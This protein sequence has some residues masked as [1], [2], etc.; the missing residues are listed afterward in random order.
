V[1]VALVWRVLIDAWVLGELVLALVT[2]TWRGGQDRG[3]QLL[4]WAVI[5]ASVW[6]GGWT[7]ARHP[8]PMPFPPH[9]VRSVALAFLFVGLLI[10][11]AAIFSLKRAFSANVA[12]RSGQT[13][14]RRGLYRVVRHP[15]YLGLELILFAAGLHACDWLSLSIVFVASTLAILY[16]IHVEETALLRAFGEDYADYMRSTKRLIPGLF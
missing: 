8:V 14:E 12:I 10:R 3:T 11:V 9:E 15:S 1:S 2:R 16:R 5:V 4:I 13:L 6:L 7:G